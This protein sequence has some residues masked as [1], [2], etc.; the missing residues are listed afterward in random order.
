MVTTLAFNEKTFITGKLELR[1]L[2]Q[3]GYNSQWIKESML[4]KTHFRIG[5]Y[6]G[7]SYLWCV[8]RFDTICT[9]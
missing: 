9:I 4:G 1:G 6:H 5:F 8:A 2:I 3:R 7:E